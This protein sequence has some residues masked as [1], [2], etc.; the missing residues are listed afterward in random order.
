MWQSKK[1]F[2]AVAK[3]AI[4]FGLLLFPWPGWYA[5]YSSYFRALGGTFFTREYEQRIVHFR[6]KEVQRQF[7]GLDSEMLIGNR[8]FTDS[9]GKG[10]GRSVGLDTISIGWTPTALTIALILATPVPWRQRGWALLWGLILIHAFILFSLQVAIW[11]E[12]QAVSLFTLSPFWKTLV[13]D[14]DYTLLTQIG[15]SFSMP[16][17][18]WILVT[19][20]PENLFE[21][22]ET[23]V[24][25]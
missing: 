15:A 8:A 7:S 11:N 5:A 21:R 14:L 16:I 12:S 9:H 20:R 2:T 23:K 13:Q 25:P 3:F 24:G 10:P 22:S 17:L 1:I 19:I 6:A 4:I 18:I